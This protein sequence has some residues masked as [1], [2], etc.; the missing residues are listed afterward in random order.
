[1][2]LIQHIDRRPSPADPNTLTL[3][4]EQT[5]F[6]RL[7]QPMVIGCGLYILTIWTNVASHIAFRWIGECV[8]VLDGV[9][10]I[11]A[12]FINGRKGSTCVVCEVNVGRL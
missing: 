11:S 2:F 1:M 5:T 4:Q 9:V 6:F 12:G 8:R 10:L 3:S 7:Q